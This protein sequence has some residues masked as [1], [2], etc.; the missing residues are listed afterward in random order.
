MTAAGTLEV[1]DAAAW[2]EATL[3]GDAALAALATGGVWE[4]VAPPEATHPFVVHQLLANSDDLLASGDRVIVAATF[5]VKAVTEA[6]SYVPLIPLARRIDELLHLA[7]IADAGDDSTLA[8]ARRVSTV[9]YPTVEAG[10]QY[11][12]LGGTYR[13]DLHQRS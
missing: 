13:L 9:R 5:V 10:R 7:A 12:H 1:L 2:L 8:G 4:D 6:E 11:R 3:A